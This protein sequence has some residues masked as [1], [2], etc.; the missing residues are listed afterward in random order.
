MRNDQ[1]EMN[2]GHERPRKHVSKA[3]AAPQSSN[4]NSES[5][6]IYESPLANDDYLTKFGRKASEENGT[7]ES[8]N[9]GMKKC[10]RLTEILTDMIFLYPFAHQ[11]D[12]LNTL[13]Q[14]GGC[15]SIWVR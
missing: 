13:P 2:N 10:L 6:I 5:K 14:R 1:E 7:G 11:S 12:S 9:W 15:D 3:T 8:R 4:N